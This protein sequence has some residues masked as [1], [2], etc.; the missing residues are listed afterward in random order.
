M[1]EVTV[2][3]GSYLLGTI[4]FGLVIVRAWRGV[5][6]REYGSGNIGATNV[7][8]VAGLAPAAVVFA[9]DMAKGLVPVVITKGLLPGAPWMA[10]A[11]GMLAIL[12]H[13]LSVFL[14]FRGGKGAATGLGVII[15]LDAR[16]A[17]IAF[18]IWLLVVGVSK[19]VSLASIIATASVPT[20]M[21][22]LHLPVEYQTFSLLAACLV[23]V[24]HRS[25]IARLAK[26][27]E[28]RLGE[29]A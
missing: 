19:Y 24:R 28:P 6:I 21:W 3:I 5:D 7:L 14:R 8:R 2:L 29:K 13:S 15:G 12:G 26:G 27:K 16:V 25:N 9:A 20:L 10:V 18:A 22:I 17:G 23:V 11:S 1:L 4:P